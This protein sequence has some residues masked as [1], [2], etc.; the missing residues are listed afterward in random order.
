[1]ADCSCFFVL[2]NP[3]PKQPAPSARSA[4]LE[5][6]LAFL[7]LGLTAF[8]GPVAHLAYFRVEFVERRQWINDRDYADLVALCQFLPGP[9]SS[10]VGFALGFGRAGWAGAIVAWL[11]FTL[12][13]ALLLMLFALVMQHSQAPSAAVHGLKLAAL[14]VVAQALWAMARSLC[15]DRPRAGI[16]IA[17]ALLALAIPSALGQ[18][19]A[20][21]AAGMVG[22]GW[23]EPLPLPAP[24]PRHPVLG[25]A[26]GAVLLLV[27]ALLLLLSIAA[28]DTPSLLGQFAAFY[29]A[30]ALVFGGG[31][32]V[33]ALLQAAVVPP[34]W[35]TQDAFIAG[36]GL[37]QAV[38]GPLFAFAAYLGALMPAPMGGWMGG[39]VL[40]LALFLP[41]L[42]LVLGALPFWQALRQFRAAQ[43]AMA[44]ANAAVVGLL[45]AALYDPLWTSSVHTRMD[46]G[47]ALTAF[48]LLAY[49]R[50]SPLR[51]VALSAIVG[52]VLL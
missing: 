49:G 31:H 23:L 42:L 27:F 25:K 12:P 5:V 6:F 35:I 48:A 36:Y 13:S 14:A 15:P 26:A 52:W 51:V 16:A 20:I 40:L 21:V 10:Q 32:V 22:L 1:M 28:A 7:K 8:G 30:G 24:R 38:P 19:A 29:Q 33:L 50:Q 43:R 3:A 18:L 44:G 37:A 41:G 47:I 17:A 39:A 2:M 11:A 9:A 34:G 4:L 46:F 45:L